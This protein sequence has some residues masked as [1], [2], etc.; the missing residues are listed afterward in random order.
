MGPGTT[1][2]P[3]VP[4]DPPICGKDPHPP[5]PNTV[6]SEGLGFTSAYGGRVVYRECFVSKSVFTIIVLP[7][8]SW[9]THTPANPV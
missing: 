9:E 3:T 1:L 6:R 4:S 8:L 7:L 2:L 5:P